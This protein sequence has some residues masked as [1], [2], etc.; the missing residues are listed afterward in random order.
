MSATTGEKEREK[1][2]YDNDY[3]HSTYTQEEGF[4]SENS[5]ANPKSDI[6]T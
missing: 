5:H 3:I 2:E 1:Q 6:L 4:R